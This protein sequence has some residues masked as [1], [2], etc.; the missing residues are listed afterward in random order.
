MSVYRCALASAGRGE[1][2]FGTA[3]GVL[4]WLLVEQPGPWQEQAPPR[5]RMDPTAH[6]RCL[7]AAGAGRA[8]LLT[9]RRP[10]RA[11]PAERRTIILAESRIGLERLLARHVDWDDDLADLH[12]PPPDQTSP[13][14]W[15]TLPGPVFL[16]CTHAQ[17]DLCC[18][19][20]GRPVAAALAARL[21]EQVWECSHVG[22]DRFAGNLVALPAGHY[23]GRVDAATAPPVA[24]AYL[25]GRLMTEYLRGRSSLMMPAQ[26]AQHFARTRTGLV[27]VDD[28]APLGVVTLDPD[29]WRISL[30]VPDGTLEVTVH[31]TL[32]DAALL[33]CAAPMPQ[34]PV[35]YELVELVRHPIG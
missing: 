35:A 19:L 32:D 15:S 25:D 1:P 33:T 23:F 24:D 26:A 13:A 18:A 22:G 16:V 28:L 5:G 17:H 11:I 31:R 21:P 8:R 9:I 4:R 27:G 7:T 29:T 12:L 20:Q 3:S 2:M 10:G 14:G 30:A 34:H 6:S